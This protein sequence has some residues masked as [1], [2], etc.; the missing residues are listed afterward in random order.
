VL[1]GAEEVRWS[2][3][4]SPNNQV[5][6]ATV[7]SGTKLK[8][9]SGQVTQKIMPVF[10]EIGPDESRVFR[11]KASA[12]ADSADGVQYQE[13]LPTVWGRGQALAFCLPFAVAVEKSWIVPKDDN[14]ESLTHYYKTL[15]HLFSF[16]IT[17]LTSPLATAR[18]GLGNGSSLSWTPKRVAQG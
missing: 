9:E 3:H 8:M 13:F 5:K 14:F 1:N 11:V 12:P 10:R 2:L 16:S 18:S 17:K 4:L 15:S 6:T 7:L